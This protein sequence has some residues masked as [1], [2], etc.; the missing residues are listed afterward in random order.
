MRRRVSREVIFAR[1]WVLV[2][3][4]KWLVDVV[5]VQLVTRWT[6]SFMF[7]FAFRFNLSVLLSEI[8]TDPVKCRSTCSLHFATLK[9]MIQPWWRLDSHYDFFS[10]NWTPAI[11]FLLWLVV[12]WS[13]ALL[14]A[15]IHGLWQ[16]LWFSKLDVT[17]VSDVDSLVIN[18]FQKLDDRTSM[19]LG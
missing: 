10:G 6:N 7:A 16:K 5:L 11:W 15:H 3:W 2:L 14:Y 18:S 12:A 13:D 17:L 9:S 4:E 8:L 19:L 1:V